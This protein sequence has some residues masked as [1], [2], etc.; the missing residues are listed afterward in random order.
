MSDSDRHFSSLVDTLRP[1]LG[2]MIFIGGW[3]HQLYRLRPEAASLSYPV[4]RTDDADL[5]LDPRSFNKSQ[6]V[7]ARLLELGFSEDMSGDDR[8]PV[9]HYVLS[10]SGAGFYAEFLTPSSALCAGTE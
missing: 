9:T 4:L 6:D 1:W 3:A 7:R 5:A 10:K 2:Q 8:P